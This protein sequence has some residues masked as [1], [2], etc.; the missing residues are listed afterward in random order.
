M[1]LDVTRINQNELTADQYF[2]EDCSSLKSILV[3]H[4]T[5]GGSSPK[6]VIYG[7]Q[8]NPEKV[9]T[10]FIIAGKPSL[11]DTHR[12]GE[13]FQSFGSKYWAYHIA[14]SKSTNNVPAKYHNFTHEQK[15]AR[16]SI[17]IEIANWG[18]LTKGE[19]GVFR[20]YVN[21]IVPAEEVVTFEN[22]FR[23][24]VHYHAYTD[25]QIASLKELIIYLCDKYK[26]SKKYN[27]DMWDIS[28][29]ALDGENGIW[30]HV[31]FRSDKNDACSQPKLV[32][33]LQEIEQ[34]I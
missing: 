22:K 32:K 15:I 29:R 10:A 1:P 34:G 31:S 9:A 16:A 13:I 17:G 25:A 21:T 33:M 23:N 2:K 26:I 7:W 3:I 6:N 4:H 5:A 30:S 20:T 12:D 14:F 19:D 28:T 27:S 8:S 18:Q 24:F 11:K